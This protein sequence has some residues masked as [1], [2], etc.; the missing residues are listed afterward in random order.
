M[1]NPGPRSS[2]LRLRKTL[3]LELI[4]DPNIMTQQKVQEVSLSWRHGQV[5]VQHVQLDGLHAHVLQPGHCHHPHHFT[6]ISSTSGEQ[7][8]SEQQQQPEQQQQQRLPSHVWVGEHE[9]PVRG[10]DPDGLHHDDDHCDACRGSC[11]RTSWQVALC[12]WFAVG[13]QVII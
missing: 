3:L 8:D 12:V 4:T 7:C 10:G 9:H 1:T 5:W 11:C 13:V 6:W 2:Y